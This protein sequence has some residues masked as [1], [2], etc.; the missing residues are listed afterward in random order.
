MKLNCSTC[1]NII[2]HDNHCRCPCHEE[3]WERLNGR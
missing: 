3:T 2:G 1:A